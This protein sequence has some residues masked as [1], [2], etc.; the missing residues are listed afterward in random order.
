ML[1]QS[2]RVGERHQ[3]QLTSWKIYFLFFLSLNLFIGSAR[4]STTDLWKK[5]SKY[6]INVKLAWYGTADVPN[7][8]Q[9]SELLGILGLRKHISSWIQN[10]FKLV[11][12]SGVALTWSVACFSLETSFLLFLQ[13]YLTSR[14]WSAI[15]VFQF[16]RNQ[17]YYKRLFDFLII[18]WFLV[19]LSIATS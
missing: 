19:Q 14:N 2:W 6:L 10:C 18:A 11:W 4:L 8:K 3:Q 16:V 7:R 13:Q 1:P 17:S 9:E 15:N 5:S 12:C